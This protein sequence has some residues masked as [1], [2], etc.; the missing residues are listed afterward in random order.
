[1]ASSRALHSSTTLG[2]AI[3]DRRMSPQLDNGANLVE[4]CARC[5]FGK[6]LSFDDEYFE[7][8][9][10]A[11]WADRHLFDFDQLWT[12]CEAG[13]FIRAKRL[14]AVE[15]NF[16]IDRTGRRLRL[17]DVLRF[18]RSTRGRLY[19]RFG[20]AMK[21]PTLDLLISGLEDFPIDE[22]N[23]ISIGALESTV[24]PLEPFVNSNQ[25]AIELAG[26]SE[27]N[28]K[29]IRD[30]FSR[31]PISVGTL[32]QNWLIG[33]STMKILN[34]SLVTPTAV[35]VG[36][37]SFLLTPQSTA[38]N[39][40]T[41]AVSELSFPSQVCNLYSDPTLG[42]SMEITK[43]PRVWKGRLVRI[44][45]NGISWRFAYFADNPRFSLSSVTLTLV[46]LDAR[47]RDHQ[48]QP[49]TPTIANF[50]SSNR[51]YIRNAKGRSIFFCAA[52]NWPAALVGAI[53]GTSSFS[54]PSSTTFE[55]AAIY[56]LVQNTTAILPGGFVVPVD[57]V[58]TNYWATRP[59]IAKN[60]G[61][62]L[63]L[64]GLSANGLTGYLSASVTSNNFTICPL[65]SIRFYLT[66]DSPTGSRASKIATRS[67]SVVNK[68]PLVTVTRYGN[69]YG[70]TLNVQ[71]N[72]ST[73]INL[74][75]ISIG[76]LWQ[77]NEPTTQLVLSES[78]LFNTI[79]WHCFAW[80]KF[81]PCWTIADS[82]LGLDQLIHESDVYS[83]RPISEPDTHAFQS[84]L[85]GRIRGS[86][87]AKA[88][89]VT[90]HLASFALDPNVVVNVAEAE[91]WWCPGED[92]L[93]LT[94]QFCSFGDSIWLDAEWTEDGETFFKRHFLATLDSQP[95]TGCF[96]Y[97]IGEGLLRTLYENDCAGIGDWFGHRAKF[98]ADPTIYSRTISGVLFTYLL[99]GTPGN[100]LCLPSSLINIS[101]LYD[102]DSGLALISG[103]RFEDAEALDKNLGALL[104]LGQTALSFS[105]S[106][107]TPYAIARRWIG[108]PSRDET[109]IPIDESVLLD[110]PIAERSSEIVADYELR[111]AD[112]KTVTYSDRLAKS[113]FNAEKTFELDLSL[114]PLNV[115]MSTAALADAIVGTLADLVNRFGAERMTYSFS[116]PFE[117]GGW[118][119]PG[120]LIALSCS[121]IVGA[122]SIASP[123]NLACRVLDVSQDLSGQTTRLRV[124]G[125]SRIVAKYQR[126]SRVIGGWATTTITV[127]D[128]SWISVGA[129][130]YAAGNTAYVVQGKSG[131]QLT[132]SS[133]F[134]FC[135]YLYS[136]QDNTRFRFG[137]DVLA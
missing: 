101:S 27:S 74:P 96:R 119:T 33:E 69:S 91:N 130:V 68:D 36:P 102:N 109:P 9:F 120:D 94:E 75:K 137:V 71:P 16:G 52:T 7:L 92:E 42:V 72:V 65:D 40:Q 110:V 134:P 46:P 10:F 34:S 97:K 63:G 90:S 66:A 20:E 133:A 50:H 15:P 17:W 113:L 108:A 62:Y 118:I 116:V 32:A 93:C 57:I 21:I 103:W 48:P 95:V 129:T 107:S 51:S 19:D 115:S 44:R 5:I 49:L 38:G 24:D 58:S 67:T 56:S 70:S 45:L 84:V 47:I 88:E 86:T 41:C 37:S 78:G 121:R 54:I 12:I 2:A 64:D 123:V 89:A 100:V 13:I 61:G 22:A 132:F 73:T 85:R 104:A 3:D 28:G 128:A 87:P 53:A 4:W 1:M 79:S 6:P 11:A 135:T 77:Q 25:F 136:A 30:L 98:S 112:D 59:A 114:C 18:D 43:W 31:D 127:D 105:C 80:S 8:R 35:C 23:I 131:N 60:G 122:S 111:F 126:G 117:V 55:T 83:L 39:V 99:G 124:V 106:E 26:E 81:K 82:T 76:F 125:D 14:C 29:Q